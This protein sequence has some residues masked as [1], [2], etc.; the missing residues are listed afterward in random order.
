LISRIDRLNTIAQLQE[1]LVMDVVIPQ[2]LSK[3]GLQTLPTVDAQLSL[4][5]L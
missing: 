3:L 5:F 2:D 4:G 1:Y